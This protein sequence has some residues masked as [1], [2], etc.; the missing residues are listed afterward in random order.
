MTFIL[1]IQTG[2]VQMARKSPWNVIEIAEFPLALY[3]YIF[4]TI[5]KEE[6]EDLSLFRW[7]YA[8][9]IFETLQTIG[10]SDYFHNGNQVR[11]I[12]V[13]EIRKRGAIRYECLTSSSYSDIV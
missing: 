2:V 13:T 9:R 3:E 10:L 8:D 5:G 12:G 6:S 4:I 11:Q 7:N 1:L